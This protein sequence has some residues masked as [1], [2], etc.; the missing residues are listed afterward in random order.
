MTEKEISL[1]Y[2]IEL[3]LL[4]VYIILYII[5]REVNSVWIVVVGIRIG[6]AHVNAEMCNFVHIV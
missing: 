4:Y 1:D 6:R 5:C 2:L 3:I